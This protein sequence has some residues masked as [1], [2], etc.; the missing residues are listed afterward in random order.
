MMIRSSA[1]PVARAAVLRATAARVP[2]A[3][4]AVWTHAAGRS[5]AA[6]LSA[7]VRHLSHS[8]ARHANTMKVDNPYTGDVVAEVPLLDEAGANR[9]L[10]QAQKVQNTWRTSKLSDRVALVNRWMKVFTTHKEEI[11]QSVSQQMGK[12]L[13]QARG[14]VETCVKRAEALVQLAQQVLPEQIIMA[15][16]N[17]GLLRKITKEPIGVVLALVPWNYPLLCA[18]NS[19]VTAVLAGNSVLLKHSDRT[20]QVADWFEKTFAAAGASKGL[21]TAFHADHD[22]VNKV[23]ANPIVAYVQFTGSVAGGRA[24][25]KSVAA[26]R[27]IDVGLELGG[28]DP[29][30]V[31]ADAD[32]SYAIANVVDGAMYNAGQSCCAV[33]RVYVHERHYDAFLDGAAKALKEY[34]L[35]DPLQASTTMGPIA[36]ARHVQFLQSHV[37]E[38]V[39]QGARL[40]V[41]GKS[42]TDKH[43][44]GRFF[45]PTLLADCTPQMRVVREESFGPLMA[46]ARVGSDE[47]AIRLMNDSDFGLTASVWS[48][49]VER[50]TR[51]G[52]QINAGTVYMNRCDFLDPYLAWSGRKDSGKG[53]GLSEHGFAPFLRTKSW[54]FR[55]NT[56]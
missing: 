23:I 2:T 40:L 56:K 10:E 6:P 17:S 26:S 46:V 9:L 15:D 32:L 24:V 18:V 39:Q 54:N 11:A 51:L 36:Q 14:E 47:E 20:P 44:K 37:D 16:P 30:Y 27:F 13:S 7:P 43:G 34:Q 33:E 45:Q 28:K 5:A 3:P 31:A 55:P 25:Y 52:E 22:L 35:G 19:V 38:A 50:A 29:A 41:G 4:S 42:T 12:P 21:V 49:D 8:A 53:I 48:S 1:A